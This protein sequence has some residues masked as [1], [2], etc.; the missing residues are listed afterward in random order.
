M[1]Q[2]VQR[3]NQI[4]TPSSCTWFDSHLKRPRSLFL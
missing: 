4:G 3:D 1:R 2:W